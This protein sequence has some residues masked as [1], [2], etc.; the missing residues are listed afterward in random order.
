MTKNSLMQA[1]STII[2]IYVLVLGLLVTGGSTEAVELYNPVSKTSCALPALPEV[3]SLH[4]Q[5]GPLL[6]GGN[7]NTHLKP[8]QSCMLLNSGITFLPM[9]KEY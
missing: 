2:K 5:D 1:D 7:A 4:S 9:V 8:R 3:R 6:C